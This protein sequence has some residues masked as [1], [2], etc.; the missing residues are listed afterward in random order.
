[1]N[2]S[3]DIQNPFRDIF[4]EFSNKLE[5]CHSCDLLSEKSRWLFVRV[6]KT[7]GRSHALHELR[8]T[9]KHYL[10]HDSFNPKIALSYTK[11]VDLRRGGLLAI[12]S[13]G[14]FLMAQYD[15]ISAPRL[16]VC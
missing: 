6:D 12:I 15:S 2:R 9:F 1:M 13:A 5:T 11:P 7:S 10:I 14:V 3:K 16:L 8:N 4:E